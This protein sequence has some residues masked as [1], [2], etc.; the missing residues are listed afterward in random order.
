MKVC[1]FFRSINYNGRNFLHLSS[2]PT[3]VSYW[4]RTTSTNKHSK[5]SNLGRAH[6]EV[7]M[8]GF[9]GTQAKWN[10]AN[11]LKNDPKKE[12]GLRKKKKENSWVRKW[13]YATS[14]SAPYPNPFIGC[15]SHR[16]EAVVRRH[17]PPED[18]LQFSNTKNMFSAPPVFPPTMVTRYFYFHTRVI[19]NT[20][21][22]LFDKM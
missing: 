1:T 2:P 8:L 6:G 10:A 9:M 14:F 19:I 21:P 16:P 5:S 12:N 20:G 15:G 18:P 11:G 17:L 22:N 7:N 3:C 13:H 4:Q